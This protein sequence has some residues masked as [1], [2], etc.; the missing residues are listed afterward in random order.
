MLIV[1]DFFIFC[2]ICM[3]KF[4][5][6]WIFNSINWVFFKK[7]FLLVVKWMGLDCWLNN[8]KLIFCFS[9][10]I[11]WL[12]VDWVM[13][14]FL[15]VVLKEFVLFNSKVYFNCWIFII[16]KINNSIMI[17][18]MVNDNFVSRRLKKI[19]Y[20]IIGILLKY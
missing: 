12:I 17:I 11:C 15:V 6:W 5:S 18:I 10:V 2:L 3:V 14:V 9:L 4:C 20:L 19:F 1:S 16:S 8:I 7:C 13:C